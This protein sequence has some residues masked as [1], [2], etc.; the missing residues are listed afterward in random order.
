MSNLD[1]ELF[2]SQL[3]EE[4]FK[5]GVH[6]VVHTI[7]EIS[8]QKLNMTPEGQL[9]LIL[10]AGVFCPPDYAVLTLELS[11]F[12]VPGDHPVDIV[13]WSRVAHTKEADA[14][15]DS[16]LTG[17]PL[18]DPIGKTVSRNDVPDCVSRLFP[19]AQEFRH[20]PP[21]DIVA[22]M[23]W[24]SRQ[25][26]SAITRGIRRATTTTNNTTTSQ[27]ENIIASAPITML[28]SKVTRAEVVQG[29]AQNSME[30]LGRKR[31]VRERYQKYSGGNIA[32]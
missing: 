24:T 19:D 23:R 10:K 16:L 31:A 1:Q 4:T 12:W 15:R 30:V 14:H 27:L 26:R 8:A 11:H 2:W 32:R 3:Q 17:S 25:E 29:L 22:F 6:F 21:S 5:E 9:Q 20:V 28:T 13:M 18:C 7:S